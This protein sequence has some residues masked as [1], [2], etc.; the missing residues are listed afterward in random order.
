MVHINQKTGHGFENPPPTS[1]WGGVP[2][3]PT[4]CGKTHFWHWE[5][6]KFRFCGFTRDLIAPILSILNEDVPSQTVMCICVSI[7]IYVYMYMYMCVHIYMLHIHIYK[8]IYIYIYIYM[9]TYI[10]IYI[11]IYMNTYI[12]MY[13]YIWIYTH[14][15]RHT[16]IHTHNLSG[17][18]LNQDHF[19]LSTSILKH[20]CNIFIKQLFLSAYSQ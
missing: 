11:Y 13:I 1:F 10:Y 2:I 8:Y 16:H 6:L 20:V 12:Y 17:S 3:F 14:I 15:H 18:T 9:Y 4:L 7:C 19:Y 5:I